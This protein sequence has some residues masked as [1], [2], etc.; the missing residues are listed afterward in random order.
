MEIKKFK[1]RKAAFTITA[2][3]VRKNYFDKNQNE[4]EYKLL[5]E[6]QGIFKPKI[7]EDWTYE[8]VEV[9]EGSREKGFL[10]KK[11]PG[12]PMIE[13]QRI[14]ESYYYHAG[15]W[16]GHFHSLSRKK[17][18][19]ETFGDYNFSNLFISHKK[20][21]ITALDPDLKAMEKRNYY[22]DIMKFLE[23]AYLKS[24]QQNLIYNKQCI[25]QFVKGYRVFGEF[26]YEA[27]Y[28]MENQKK[29]LGDLKRALSRRHNKMYVAIGV[30]VFKLYF[31][32][33]LK[34]RL[35]VL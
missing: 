13:D 14:D 7:F 22:W 4:K 10:M 6:M 33:G 11:I 19:V 24:L 35:R 32:F 28:Y 34:R 20:K 8:L 9:I 17:G 18:R 1:N 12:R 16:L 31:N 27:E 26:Q 23:M 5:I 3:T 25:E 2:D 21:K 29:L 30:L 15:I